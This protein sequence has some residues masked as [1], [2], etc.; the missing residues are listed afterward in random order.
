MAHVGWSHPGHTSG[1]SQPGGRWHTTS[2]PGHTGHTGGRRQQT[3]ERRLAGG[4]PEMPFRVFERHRVATPGQT[5]A[6]DDAVDGWAAM[7][8]RGSDRTNPA[9]RA[10]PA[11]I[12]TAG[13]RD[14]LAREVKLLGA[15][16]GQVIAEQAGEPLLTRIEAIR[17]RA[18]ANRR[19]L[20]G[21]PPSAVIEDLEQ[22][23]LATIETI[24]RAFGLYFQVINVAEERDRVRVLRRRE[25]AG[26]G[27]PLEDSLAAAIDRLVADGMSAAGI[28]AL[29]GGLSVAPVLTAHPTEARRRTLLL[30]L[31]RVARLVERLDDPRLTPGEDRDLRRR[32]RE[33]ITLLWR[34]AELRSIAP[35]PLDEVRSA[36]V[37]FDETLFRV[38]PIVIRALVRALDQVT[39]RSAPASGRPA[40]SAAAESGRLARSAPS[41][42]VASDS[43]ETGTRPAGLGTF[44]HW[45]SWIGAD[46][47]GNP[48]VTAEV[49]AQAARIHA[50]HGLRGHEAVVPRLMQTIASTVPAGQLDRRI[51]RRLLVDE[52][53]LPELM[54][55]LDRG[56]PDEPD[57]RRLGAMAERL[58]RT[59]SALIGAAAPL[60]GRYRDADAFMTE[61][62]ELSAALVADGLE[63]VAYGEIHDLRWQV[64]TFG[65]H[66]AD[67]EV[68]Q[69]SAVQAAAL[70]ALE[71]GPPD[72]AG[73]QAL[74]LL[75]SLR[76]V[77][78]IQ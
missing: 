30:A 63:R 50:D 23:D 41:A 9:V 18:K 28:M 39:Q 15:L 3:R 60:T 40:P 35:S 54:R 55:Q 70:R 13:A 59:R 49:T 32:L 68:R 51:A 61:L 64:E 42:R 71:A 65:F 12:G 33:E 21:T 45:G 76:A 22:L 2:H 75:A 43:G 78:Q 52:D 77:A 62:D 14:P 16:L 38:T 53:E 74:E 25:R 36:M 17:A 58:R 19:A 6:C 4:H 57:R 66:L 47:D 48:N 5:C 31:R 69:H 10:E 26:R 8:A 1:S 46:R 11:G 20:D 24:I 27:A 67:L 29:V 72:Q 56:F 37:F 7:T 44:L 34:T 73:P